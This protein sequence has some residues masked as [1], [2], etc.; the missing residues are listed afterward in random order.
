MRRRTLVVFV[1]WQT[2]GAFGAVFWEWTDSAVLWVVGFFLLL[3]GNL[4]APRGFLIHA[5]SRLS[6]GATVANA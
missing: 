4:V 3:P 6:T 1:L 5:D 2:L